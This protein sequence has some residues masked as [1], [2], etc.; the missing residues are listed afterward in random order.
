MTPQPIFIIRQHKPWM[1]FLFILWHLMLAACIHFTAHSQTPASN[2]L[3][4]VGINYLTDLGL[5]G[6]LLAA[7]LV[8]ISFSAIFGLAYETSLG[9]WRA[10]A[11]LAPQYVILFI[12]FLTDLHILLLGDFN[13]RH[14]DRWIILAVLGGFMIG[15]LLHTGA[16]LERYFY[17]WIDPEETSA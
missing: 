5:K 16:I 11:F 7:F 2:L 14:V 1:L 10:F 13:G 12:A 4:L 17:D 15:A 6:D 8:G 3:V 9:R